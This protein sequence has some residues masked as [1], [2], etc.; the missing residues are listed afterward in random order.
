MIYRFRIVLDS[1]EDIFRDLELK[2]STTFEDLH[3]AIIQSF[4][5]SGHE[6]ATFYICDDEWNQG[7]AIALTDMFEEPS[8]LMEQTALSDIFT[9]EQKTALY[10]YDFLNMWTFF[11]TCVEKAESISGVSYPHLVFS[12]GIVPDEAPP[13]QYE[14]THEDSNDMGYESLDDN[15]YPDDEWY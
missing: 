14:Q 11:V 7:E 10:V 4:G 1:E 3:N 6:M 9:E 2:S 15:G 5:L 8:L 12:H 13:K